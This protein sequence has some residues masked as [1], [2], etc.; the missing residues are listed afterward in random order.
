[1]TPAERA[2]LDHTT[3]HERAI[4]AEQETANA[5]VVAESPLVDDAPYNVLDYVDD[6][7][8]DYERLEDEVDAR[9]N[10]DMGYDR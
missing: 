3:L 7:A 2:L 1:M 9:Y 6:I 5:Q 4:L 8:D 10:R